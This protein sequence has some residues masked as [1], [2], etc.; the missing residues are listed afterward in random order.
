[1][2][3]RMERQQILNRI[4][5]PRYAAILDEGALRRWIGGRDVLLE[6]LQ[7]LCNMATRHNVDLRVLPFANG[8]HQA[9]NGSFTILDFPDPL[10][11]PV[12]FTET[13][14]ASLFVEEPTE[15]AT[16][17]DVWANLQGAALTAAK[18]VEFIQ[19]V[20]RELSSERQSDE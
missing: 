19:Q 7:H 4:H 9:S 6:Q 2:Q 1:M 16:Y 5:P 11:T 10:D 8:E 17:N 18:S 15:L 3:G 20:M 12:A 14:T 13:V